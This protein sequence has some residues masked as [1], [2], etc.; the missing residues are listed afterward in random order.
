MP[1][2]VPLYQREFKWGTDETGWAHDEFVI[3]EFTLQAGMFQGQQLLFRP[4]F[5]RGS[6][7]MMV[8]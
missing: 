4:G 7:E 5:N 8:G 3:D 2:S 6:H 1:F